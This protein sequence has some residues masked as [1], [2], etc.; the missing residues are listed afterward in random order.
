M[1][2]NPSE[3]ESKIMTSLADK[4][5]SASASAS[6]HDKKDS[7]DLG[8]LIKLVVSK[9][10]SGDTELI[11]MCKKHLNLCDEEQRIEFVVSSGD[12]KIRP[13]KGVPLFRQIIFARDKNIKTILPIFIKIFGYKTDLLKVALEFESKLQRDSFI[14]SHQSK[15]KYWEADSILDKLIYINTTELSKQA[16]IFLCSMIKLDST[17]KDKIDSVFESGSAFH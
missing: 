2:L 9:L 13:V 15:S 17:W 14:T 16:W 7:K 1:S 6:D 4:K 3:A 8:N 11:E 10:E 12:F 5:D